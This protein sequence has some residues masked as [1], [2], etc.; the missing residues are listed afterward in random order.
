M[1]H[2][3]CCCKTAMFQSTRARTL[4]AWLRSCVIGALTESLLPWE[5]REPWWHSAVALGE[6]SSQSPEP[7]AQLQ[8]MRSSKGP[9][10]GPVACTALRRWLAGPREDPGNQMHLSTCCN[11]SSMPKSMTCACLAPQWLQSQVLTQAGPNPL[12]VPSLLG[13]GCQA[14]GHPCHS[15]RPS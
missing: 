15:P 11:C 6:A 8:T 4:K 1:T 5:F 10:G 2:R 14:G 7:P 3:G 12:Q 9:G 13:Y